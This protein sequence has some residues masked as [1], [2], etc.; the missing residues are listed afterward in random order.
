MESVS[1]AK[2]EGESDS[3]IDE[4][5][6][7]RLAANLVSGWEGYCEQSCSQNS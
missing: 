4:D 3:W 1:K 6:V 2:G 7:D 5:L